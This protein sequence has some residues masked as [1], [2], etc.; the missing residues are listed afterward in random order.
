MG[1]EVRPQL[2]FLWPYDKSAI[3]LFANVVRAITISMECSSA[4]FSGFEKSKCLNDPKPRC[5]FQV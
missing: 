4:V 3:V 5:D 1:H 2:E